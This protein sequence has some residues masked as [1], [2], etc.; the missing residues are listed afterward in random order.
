MRQHLDLERLAC[1]LGEVEETCVLRAEWENLN[2][3]LR[4][5]LLPRL[6]RGEWPALQEINFDAFD[7]E[8]PDALLE[9]FSLKENYQGRLARVHRELNCLA[10][11]CVRTRVFL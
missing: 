8:D 4:G 2:P 11:V 3:Y 9:Y 6:E 1:N 7:A 5:H 10:P